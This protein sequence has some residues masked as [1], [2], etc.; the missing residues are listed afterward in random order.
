M[1]TRE[2]ELSQGDIAYHLQ[3]ML[4]S[5]LEHI[6]G[7][8]ENPSLAR[9]KGPSLDVIE[10]FARRH[11]RRVLASKSGETYL[12]RFALAASDDMMA[13]INKVFTAPASDG[14]DVVRVPRGGVYLHRIVT[15]D[16]GELLHNHP[17]FATSLILTGGYEEAFAQAKGS[18]YGDVA[19]WKLISGDVNFLKPWTCHRINAVERDTW[20]LFA[21]WERTA[22]W[23]FYPIRD[24]RPT[25]V[26]HNDL[27]PEDFR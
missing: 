2:P 26:H 15:P 23:G 27:P 12:E 3:D 22:P 11:P 5:R 6:H 16:P 8:H 4:L 25:Y 21:V 18:S 1:D 13:M 19:V 7:L 20:T 24:G 17:W 9:K 10:A 14:L